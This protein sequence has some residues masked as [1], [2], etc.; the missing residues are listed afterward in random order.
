V[1][2]I[3]DWHARNMYV[4]GSGTYQHHLEH[5]GHPSKFGYKDIIQLWKAEKFDPDRLISLYKAAGAKYFVSMGAHH[6]NFDLWNSR[7]HRWNAVNMVPKKDIVG[8]WRDATL[9]QG[10]R[11]GV[12]EHLAPSFKWFSTAHNA[13]KNGPL[14]VVPYD[15]NDPANQPP[16]SRPPVRPNGCF[17]SLPPKANS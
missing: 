5:Y 15:G 1:A 3:G 17:R 9:K 16:F 14:A 12:S 4:E 8:L 7:Y 10:L 2:E 6:D 13:D 11:F